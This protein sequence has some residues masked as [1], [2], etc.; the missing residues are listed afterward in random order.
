MAGLTLSAGDVSAMRTVINACS[1]ADPQPGLP[2]GAMHALR[3][4]IGCDQLDLSGQDWRVRGHYLDQTVADDL[5]EAAIQAPEPYDGLGA[6][7]VFWAN[8]WDLPCS[9]PE[10]TGDYATVMKISDVLSV[11]QMRADYRYRD[12]MIARGFYREMMTAWPD[13]GGRT[14]R[15]LLWRG[16]GK[17]FTERDRFILMLLRPHLAA[18]YWTSPQPAPLEPLDL[19]ARQIEV[20][21]L[22]A[23]G[24]SNRQTARIMHLSEGTIR[25][26]LNNI[27]RQLKVTSRTA[28]VARLHNSHRW[29]ATADVEP[30]SSPN[31]DQGQGVHR[32]WPPRKHDPH[33]ASP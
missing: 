1:A 28:A 8:F 18:A 19:S 14:S 31:P 15:L 9:R 21:T 33:R 13:G 30:G 29:P 23:Q 10:R 24:H 25:T 12:N 5:E 11:A 6:G 27:Y 22:V 3:T 7:H 2:M 20:L 17:D 4:L 26:H 32:R 16:P